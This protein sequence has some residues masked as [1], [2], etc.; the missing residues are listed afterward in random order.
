M[1]EMSAKRKKT[2]A[3]KKY[4]HIFTS[5]GN[6]IAI[7]TVLRIL[8]QIRKDLGLEAMLEYQDRY[9]LTMESEYPQLGTAVT[10]V[11][12]VKGAA[13]MYNEALS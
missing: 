2:I 6:L 5:P 3:G 11:L 4:P 1:K 9:L 10:Q 13:D 12:A 7:Y 8:Q